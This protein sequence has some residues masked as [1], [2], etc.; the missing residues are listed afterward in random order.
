MRRNIFALGL[1][2]WQRKE[3]ETIAEARELDFYSLLTWDEL[4]GQR[5]GFDELLERARQQLG[6]FGGKPD[7][8]ICHWDFPSSCLAP[9]LSAEYGLPAPSLESVLKCEHKYWSRLEQQRCV[10]EC[11]PDFQ[12][13]DP[14]D[15]EAADKLRLEF[16]IWL[17][18]V[19]GYSS[20]LG[21]YIEN[22]NQLESALEEM[23]EHV[24]ELG[25]PFDECLRH[26]HLPA[27]V[28]GIGGGHAIAETIMSGDQFAPEGY[29]L[30]GQM[31]I[32]GMF[33]MLLDQDGKAVLGL[34]YPANLP[35]SLEKRTTDVCRRVLEQVG[36]DNGCF[37]IEFLWDEAA[38]KLWVI[39]VN[40]RISQSHCELF[41]LVDGMSNHE[42]AVSVAL[43]HEPHLPHER[44]PNETA[45]KFVLTKRDDAEV[46]R[47]PTEE[48]LKELSGQLGD[49]LIEIGVTEGQRLSDIPGQPVYCFNLGEAWIGADSI[50]ELMERYRE[51]VRRLPIEFS[52]DRHLEP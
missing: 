25:R 9:V 34:R 7:A 4:V 43:G 20:M 14:F 1:L 51:L 50:D 37:N 3:L 47:V 38:D 41:R 30:D 33:D 19:V 2:E 23:R 44:G 26:A 48:E 24:G 39:E 22:R 21:F 36:F 35:S 45:A 12:A 6:E 18:P 42:I 46:T 28:A 15:P 8:F 11:T 49:A 31:R 13:L 32:H 27:E 29:V 40:T 52:D 5:L 16:P 17:K 10:P